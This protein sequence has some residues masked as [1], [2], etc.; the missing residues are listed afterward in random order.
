MYKYV[1]LG[2][3]WHTRAIE[4]KPGVLESRSVK[5]DRIADGS[6]GSHPNETS[7]TSKRAAVRRAAVPPC[8][9]TFCLG[10]LWIVS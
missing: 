1:C 7:F 10:E 6:H 8:R 2:I 9:G 4:K 3:Y 5:S